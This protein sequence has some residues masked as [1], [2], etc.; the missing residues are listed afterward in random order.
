MESMII[1]PRENVTPQVA[2]HRCPPATWHKG[3]GAWIRPKP[4]TLWRISA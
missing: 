4:A 3:C 1:L 2:A